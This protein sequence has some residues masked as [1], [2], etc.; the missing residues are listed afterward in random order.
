V[1]AW[2]A[3]LGTTYEAV[4]GLAIGGYGESPLFYA[5][6]GVPLITP[7]SLPGALIGLQSFS[8]RPV[9]PEPSTWALL[10]LCGTALWWVVRGQRRT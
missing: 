10:A 1:R 4:A 8:L 5:Q 2:D 6:G 9:V 7:P 3:Q